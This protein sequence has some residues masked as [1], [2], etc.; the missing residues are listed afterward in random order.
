MGKY[1]IIIIQIRKNIK[2]KNSD[3]VCV[4]NISN[5][6]KNNPTLGFFQKWIHIKT[7]FLLKA[8]TC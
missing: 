7:F 3:V 6:N 1:I 8:C 5:Y 4:T 2:I